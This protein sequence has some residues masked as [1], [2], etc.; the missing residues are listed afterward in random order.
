MRHG[1]RPNAAAAVAALALAV[2]A[3]QPAAAVLVEGGS[4]ATD[5]TNTTVDRYYFTVDLGGTLTVAAVQLVYDPPAIAR[6]AFNIYVD[7]GV[8]NASDLVFSA[9]SP[10]PGNAALLTNRPFAAGNYVAV[11]S[12][13]PLAADEFGPVHAAPVAAGYDYEFT[14][15]GIAAN[16]SIITGRCE[17]NL[18]GTF[19]PTLNACATGTL[20]PEPSSLALLAVGAGLMPLARRRRR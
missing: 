10:G 2:A 1:I 9:A 19:T 12:E 16:D 17:G 15:A 8:L 13:Y 3:P 18:N 5:G 11:L 4:I 6:L 14:L 7:D 20:V